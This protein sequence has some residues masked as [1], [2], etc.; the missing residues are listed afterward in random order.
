MNSHTNSTCRLTMFSLGHRARI[1]QQ[2]Q[3]Q[4]PRCPIACRPIPGNIPRQ[5]VLSGRIQ[6]FQGRFCRGCDW[7]QG[8]CASSI[9]PPYCYSRC[10]NISR[11]TPRHCRIPGPV[12]NNRGFICRVCDRVNSSCLRRTAPRIPIIP[13]CTMGCQEVVNGTPSHCITYGRLVNYRGRPCRLCDRVDFSCVRRNLTLCASAL[14]GCKTAP[15]GLPDFCISQNVSN[16]VG[17]PPCLTCPVISNSSRCTFP[18]CQRCTPLTQ[19]PTVPPECINDGDIVQPPNYPH[20]CSLCP[21]VDPFCGELEVTVCGNQ[22]ANC[23]GTPM[24]TPQK[25]IDQSVDFFLGNPCLTCPVLKTEEPG[26]VKEAY[27]ICD[28]F[29]CPTVTRQTVMCFDKGP[30]STAPNATCNT[31][32][33]L[34]RHKHSICS[35]NHSFQRF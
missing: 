19:I 24:G 34:Y 35:N 2:L 11:N 32:P 4:F 6:V 27:N 16:A 5:C 14:E 25:C 20:K 13:R 23:V 12:V 22:M 1:F 7:V 28:G 15:K 26:C 9:I 18:P 21:Y 33:I 10:Q 8:N 30:Y 17:E 31:C 29:V 3:A